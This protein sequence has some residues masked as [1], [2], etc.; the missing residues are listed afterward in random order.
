MVFSILIKI[1]P[2]HFGVAQKNE[3]VFIYI[4]GQALWVFHLFVSK[5]YSL[6]Y[7]LIFLF[8]VFEIMLIKILHELLVG[9]I[10]ISSLFQIRDNRFIGAFIH[11][12][13]V[14]L[15]SFIGFH[16]HQEFELSPDPSHSYRF[17]KF[18]FL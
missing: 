17:R 11:E 16:F 13:V 3:K 8:H 1:L 6:H 12:F 15:I 10:L 7:L 9:A 5:K 2:E 14:L 18:D 4:F